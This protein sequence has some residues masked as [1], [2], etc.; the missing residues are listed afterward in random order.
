[1]LSVLLM[2]VKSVNSDATTAMDDLKLIV[3]Q[4]R[5]SNGWIKIIPIINAVGTIELLESLANKS[6]I[7]TR[8]LTDLSNTLE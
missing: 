8:K 6:E 2:F 7:Q 4:S 5:L 3:F 1:M